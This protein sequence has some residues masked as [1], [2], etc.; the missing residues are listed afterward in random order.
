[1]VS[2]TNFGDFRIDFLGEDEAICETASVRES[3]PYWG[4]FYEQKPRV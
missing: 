3:G 2:M 4:L 1:M